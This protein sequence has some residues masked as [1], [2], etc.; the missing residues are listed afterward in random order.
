MRI[1]HTSDWH[2][3]ARL[4][5][6]DRL[7]DQLARIE[8]ICNHIDE[9][10]VDLLL[11]AGDVFDEHRAEALAR[12]IARLGRRLAP[13]IQSGLSCVFIA[14]NHDR[15]HVF[16]LLRGLQELVSPDDGRRVIFTDRPALERVTSRSGETVNLMLLPYPTPARYDLA[17]QRWS[18]PDVKR[19][20]LHGELRGRMQHLAAEVKSLGGGVQTVVCGHFWIR[21]VTEGLYRVTEQDDIVLDPGDLPAYPYIALGHIHKPQQVAAPYIRYCGSIER[22]DRGEKDDQK[23]VVVAEVTRTGLQGFEELPLNATPFAHLEVSSEAELEEQAAKVTEPDRTLVSVTANLRRDQSLASILAR[24][25]ELFP[26]LY[27]AVDVNWLNGEQ[28]ARPALD[29]NRQDV[30]GTVRTY[31]KQALEGAP[32]MKDI[33]TLAEELLE[34]AEAPQE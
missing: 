19:N 8:E 22:M 13:R 25:K 15:E 33:L 10:E 12:I 6:Q 7:T 3:G 21:G 23:Q 5:G 28:P 24:A 26:R 27:G 9:K 2:L 30:P 20:A 31:L 29:L 16:P 11:V 14:G 34:E 17:D 1:L 4:G 18:S 32:D